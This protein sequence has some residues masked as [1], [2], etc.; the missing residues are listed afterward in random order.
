[1][2]KQVLNMF[3]RPNDPAQRGITGLIAPTLGPV[4][5]GIGIAGPIGINLGKGMIAAH[6][7]GITGRVSYQPGM[8]RLV[9]DNVNTGVVPAMKRASQ[10]N[11]GKFSA[12]ANNVL[13]RG[14]GIIDDYGATPAMIS[15]LYN[16]GG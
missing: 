2:N 13:T 14:I 15:A 9:S 3:V 8:A 6:N 4:G 7:K 12:L 5:L 1:M 16:M 10:G 11:Y